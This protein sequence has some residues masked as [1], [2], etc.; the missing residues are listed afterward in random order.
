MI[1]TITANPT[2]DKVYF[3]DE[4]IMGNV[5]RAKR[6]VATAG[7]KGI[8]V[9]KVA[10]I[11]GEPV[12]AMGFLGGKT[13][14]FI[15]E[16]I[17]RWGIIDKFT[18]IDGETRTCTNISD[19][20]GKS[21]E[22]LEPGPVITPTEKN[23]FLKEFETN[24]DSCDVVCASGS[25]PKGLDSNFYCEIIEICQR[26]NKPII[27]DTSGIALKEVVKKGPFLVKPN[28]EELVQLT[29]KNSTNNEDLKT[30]LD[31]LKAKGITIPFVTLGEEGSIALVENRYYSFS[32]PQVNVKNAVGSGDS[33]IAGIAVGFCRGYPFIDAIRLGMASGVANTQFEETGMVSK[34]LVNKY[35]NKI[36]AKEL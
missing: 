11:L 6:T 22:I 10:A 29:E 23:T 15:R 1:L 21:G 9:S 12:T 19:K 34:E 3:V 20:H 27:V 8:N 31:F 7:G 17:A 25:L 36:V 18:A 4:F 28:R 24:V 14:E 16:Q 13:G 30:F 5:Y 26:H 35:Y 33:T 2:I 32:V